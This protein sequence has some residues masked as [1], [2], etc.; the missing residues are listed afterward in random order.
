MTLKKAS[1]YKNRY[2]LGTPGLANPGSSYLRQTI[3]EAITDARAACEES[4]EPQIVVKIVAVVQPLHP[5]SQ[6]VM[7]DDAPSTRR[8]A[9]RR[10]KRVGKRRSG[11]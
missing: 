4:G 7:L 6:V 10:A 2:Y 8:P 5:P 3:G 9:K 1:D 11:R